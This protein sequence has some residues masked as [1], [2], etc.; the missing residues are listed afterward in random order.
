MGGLGEQGAAPAGRSLLEASGRGLL[1]SGAGGVFLGVVVSPAQFTGHGT[2][3]ADLRGCPD[4]AW[5]TALPVDPEEEEKA[6]RPVSSVTS[7]PRS[8]EHTSELQSLR[9]L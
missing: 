2:G 7:A 1:V 8:E 3:L 5:C 4:D 6:S 9:H